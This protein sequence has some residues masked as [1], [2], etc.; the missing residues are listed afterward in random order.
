MPL[1]EHLT[2]RQRDTIRCLA[3]GYEGSREEDFA[4]IALDIGSASDLLAALADYVRCGGRRAPSRA[5]VA[6]PEVVLKMSVR[7]RLVR[8]R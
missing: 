3:C 8:V 1:A 2:G 4:D 6:L 7:A 5:S